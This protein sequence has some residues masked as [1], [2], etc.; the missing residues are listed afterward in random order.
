[1]SCN[2]INSKIVIWVREHTF[3]AFTQKMSGK[4]VLEMSHVFAES[5]VFKQQIYCSFLQ[6]LGVGR[7]RKW[8]FY[9]DVINGWN[10]YKLI[11]WILLLPRIL[12]IMIKVIQGYKTNCCT[13]F[14]P[15]QL[16]VQKNRLLILKCY[17][18]GKLF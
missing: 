6:E 3:L 10:L 5:I 11:K 9:A 15:V 4:G 13:V 12:E 17:I 18:M 8:Y 2:K 1:M 14:K 7:V 16:Q